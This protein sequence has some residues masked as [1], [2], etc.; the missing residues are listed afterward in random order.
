MRPDKRRSSVP[1]EESKPDD[2]TPIDETP[3]VE[4]PVGAGG[5]TQRSAAQD[6][7]GQD[8]PGPRRRAAAA[9]QG[10]ADE[11][12]PDGT[13]SNL[14]FPIVGIGAS[15]GGLAAY[16]AFFDHL[17]ANSGMAFI[18]V[19]HLA[20]SHESELA[21]LL[22][23]HTAIAVSQVR[24]QTVV[25]PDHVYV[26]PPG[27]T[28]RLV[29]GTL[30]LS[31]L[32]RQ[33]D[34]RSPIDIFFRSLAEDVG[35]RSVA[36]ILSGTG[37]DGTL[38][39]KRIKERG[40][41]VMAQDPDEAQYAGMPTAA[42]TTGLVDLV[43]PA[44]DLA[45]RLVDYYRYV[46]RTQRADSADDLA[47]G[48]AD[49]LQAILNAV[50]VRAGY[51]F[52]HYK[53]TTILRRIQR[54]MH[55]NRI[56][57]MRD[58]LALLGESTTEATALFK[59]FLIS[60]TN[61]FRDAE[62]FGALQRE[63]IAPIV[64]AK[65]PNEVVR[66]WVPGCSTGEEAYTLAML[67]LEEATKQKKQIGLQIFATD[68]DRGALDFGRA[69]L[70][71]TSI[72]TDVPSVYLSRYFVAEERGYRVR[73]EVRQS[74]LFAEH[75]L[76]NDPPFSSL[77]L[78]SCRN[79]LIYLQRPTQ[80]HVFNLLHYAL[81]PDGYLFLG[82]SESAEGVADLFALVNKKHCIYRRLAA[83]ARPL[84]LPLAPMVNLPMPEVQPLRVYA[85][86]PVQLA[87]L[88]ASVLLTRYAPPSLIVDNNHRI[89]HISGDTSEFLQ[90]PQGSVTDNVVENVIPA[91]RVELR[92]LLFQLF[93]QKDDPAPRELRLNRNKA[94]EVITLRVE[95]IPAQLA[96]EELALVVFEKQVEAAPRQPS[97]QRRNYDDA[98][99]E[100]LELELRRTQ[101]R[102]Q[103]VVEEY[104]TSTEELKAA[105]EELQAANEELRSTTEE[106]ESSKEELQS[107]NEELSA[108]NIELQT[109]LTEV[110]A[111]NSDLQ[112]LMASTRIATLFLDRKLRLK[113][114][115]PYTTVLFH[116]IEGD[117]GR[118]FV[119]ITH[120]VNHPD[121]AGV[122][123]EVL[124]TLDEVVQ[125]VST[126]DKRWYL[127]RMVPYRALNDEVEGV[128][129]T[130]VDITDLKRYQEQLAGRERQQA[131]VAE[132]GQL[133]LRGVTLQTLMDEAV[134]RLADTLQVPYCM[135]L[136]LQPEEEKLF[137]QAGVGWRE[138]RVGQ[139]VL[140]AG[141]NTQTAYTLRA[142]GP[143]IVE[144]L[145]SEKR[146]NAS[147]LLR[148][149]GIVS[150]V[151]VVIGGSAQPYGVLSLHATDPHHFSKQDAQFLQSVANVLATAVERHRV[152]MALRD[153]EERLRMALHAASI[154]TWRIDLTTGRTL[155]D[156]EMSRL[157]GRPMDDVLWVDESFIDYIYPDDLGTL[158]AAWDR[159]LAGEGMF[160]LEHRIVWPDGT[161]RWLRNRG[162]VTSFVD[163][164]PQIVTGLVLDITDQ[165]LASEELTRLAAIVES[166]QS[167]IIRKTP[168]GVITDWNPS[169]NRI[170]GW[171][172][173]EVVGRSVM[174]VFV[175]AERRAEEERL[176][177]RV[178]SGE[179]VRSYETVRQRRDGTRIDVSVSLS[180]IWDDQG[181]LVG[182]SAIEEDITERKEAFEQQARL[183]AIVESSQ[184]AIIRTTPQGIITDWNPAAERIF[185]WTAEEAAGQ[186]FAMLVPESGKSEWEELWT[187][188][189]AGELIRSYEITC[190]TRGG[191]AIDVSMNLSPIYDERGQLVG[192]SGIYEDIT[193]SKRAR[194][195]RQQ[196]YAQVEA[197]RAL[198]Q[199][200]LQQLPSGVMI[201]EVPSGRR[202]MGNKQVASIFRLPLRDVDESGGAPVYVGYH[203]DG[204]R[205]ARGEWPLQRAALG[206]TVH[207]EEI[208]I[209]RGDGTRGTIAASAAPVYDSEGRISAAVVVFSDISALKETEA[210]LRSLTDTLEE[211][212]H[213]RTAQVRRLA[214]DLTR[215]EEEERRRVAQV[216]HD[217]LQQLLFGAQVKLSILGEVFEE[218]DLEDSVQ[219]LGQVRKVLDDSIHVTRR[220]VVDLSPPVLEGEGL[221]E[222]V[223][224]LA[225]HMRELHGLQIKVVADEPVVF[226][227]QEIRVLL[228]HLVR[229][230]LFNVVKHAGVDEAEVHIM[231]DKGKVRLVVTDHGKGFEMEK[232]LQATSD[233]T[234]LLRMRERVRLLGGSLTIYSEPDDGTR[235]TVEVPLAG[236]R[237]EG[238]QAHP[239]EPGD[240][241]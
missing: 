82:S 50:R 6:D 213:V 16:Q 59:D 132:L 12:Q 143:V 214:A 118:P 136:A 200:V 183:A 229:E 99:V 208:S 194:I 233:S 197:E 47:D 203:A 51:D 151:S 161:V 188:L 134:H 116:L 175:P 29:G 56:E 52:S 225:T 177:A 44:G 10:Q 157:L 74:V 41:I 145:R 160:D 79:V 221:K 199:A 7:C 103:T 88:H 62:A 168:F 24:D 18:L 46:A 35:E 78:V 180:P 108:V 198:L 98:V 224:W 53:P 48:G 80:R 239:R 165:K 107:A 119:H 70:Y 241:G 120:Q 201:M 124:H 164:E 11:I 97:R 112:N 217:H 219:L 223:V 163:G 228:F 204:R 158:Q 60:V 141:D 45:R 211:R 49:T 240:T 236:D 159:T 171:P 22:Q 93:Q 182:I 100:Q 220:L 232:V 154:G 176:L 81:R 84:H 215:A 104:E 28:L 123:Q 85:Q 139:V 17:P 195:E 181:Q 152:E 36:I 83:A 4:T 14:A 146:F 184:N 235:V 63:A 138:G 13:A 15:A 186:S 117:I 190:L 110:S 227:R 178:R 42:I 101:H 76:L 216:L 113:R 66:V 122:A 144:D 231:M 90:R 3:E 125:E 218:G 65:Q 207:N 137:L 114:F 87:D 153:N 142:Q 129:A 205:Y 140:D 187:R 226:P 115:T 39:M 43:A 95:R 92:T 193:Q 2:H 127:M 20:P 109:T 148:E 23:R 40:G 61:F 238:V 1:R 77:D 67:L 26:I 57:E 155:L 191:E 31:D 192:I 212:V 69:A 111:A 234:G 121:L 167:A 75:N 196:L 33:S 38:G 37:S 27:K 102:L 130:F 106:L 73:D 55:V 21:S 147:S 149:H 9:D 131:I 72:T 25:Q 105:N 34:R 179:P 94:G 156:A 189:A 237:A 210:N 96:N 173:A 86:A 209:E 162:E 8:E 150:G 64:A 185:G 230:L 202:V 166:S 135:V 91:L 172:A 68:L 71:P 19:Q 222:A 169:A 89:R 206:E 133:A 30:T 54:R 170:F 32:Q 5:M 126:T 128:V 174:D 58:Y